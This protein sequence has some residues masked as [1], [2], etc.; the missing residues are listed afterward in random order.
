MFEIALKVKHD[1]IFGKI[2]EK[3]PSLKIF[4]WYN[5]DHEIAEIATKR[6]EDYSAIVE[7]FS[8]HVNIIE[9]HQ[10]GTKIHLITTRYRWTSETSVSKNIEDCNLLQIPP[11]I[12]ENGWEYYHVIAFRHLD[13]QCFLQSVEK[14]GFK[15]EILRKSS[16]SGFIGNTLAVTAGALFSDLTRKQMEALLV[17]YDRGY[18]RLPRKSSLTTIAKNRRIPRTTFEEHLRKAENKLMTNLIPYLRL[19]DRIPE[20]KKTA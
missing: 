17:S 12:Y 5:P 16:F 9:K 8:K 2:S 19:F 3:F 11:E 15:V 6:R 7:E 20:D 1:C 18:Y 14:K 4:L 13:I 10:D